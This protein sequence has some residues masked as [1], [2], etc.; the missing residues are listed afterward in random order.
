MCASLYLDAKKLPLTY[1]VMMDP[2]T[3]NKGFRIFIESI[4]SEKISWQ[5]W[6]K[7]WKKPKGICTLVVL[8]PTSEFNSMYYPKTYFWE[9]ITIT[10][11]YNYNFQYTCIMHFWLHLVIYYLNGK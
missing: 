11:Q 3:Q 8:K 1:L 9:H 2:G 10:K 5:M 4:S 6:Q 7:Y